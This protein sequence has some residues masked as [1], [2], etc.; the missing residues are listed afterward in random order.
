MNMISNL[1][2]DLLKEDWE[3]LG[4]ENIS[5]LWLKI[6]QNINQSLKSQLIGHIELIYKD[7]N[8]RNLFKNFTDDHY[9]IRIDNLLTD[10][11]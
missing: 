4:I 7:W 9:F 10:L 2:L 11:I 5:N 8:G 3:Q 6:N 1:I